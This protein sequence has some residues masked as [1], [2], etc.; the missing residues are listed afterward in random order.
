MR[1]ITPK[2][3]IRHLPNSIY[4]NVIIKLRSSSERVTSIH[5]FWYVSKKQNIQW[6]I[7]QSLLIPQLLSLPGQLRKWKNHMISWYSYRGKI[8][9]TMANI[10]PLLTIHQN[11]LNGWISVSSVLCSSQY[12]DTFWRKC[13]YGIY[14][15]KNPKQIIQTSHINPIHSLALAWLWGTSF[16]HF[17]SKRSETIRR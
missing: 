15:S 11:P 5:S 14:D 9:A 12:F 6:K 4:C 3:C 10:G 1:K 13:E 16:S 17:L 7:V 8:R 2:S